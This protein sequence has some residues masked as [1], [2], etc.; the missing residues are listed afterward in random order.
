[1]ISTQIYISSGIIDLEEDIP[2]NL[3]YAIA[4]IREPFN[5][6]ASYSRTITIPGSKANNK[7]FK[8]VFDLKSSVINASNSNFNPD[9]NPN[10]KAECVI[11]VDGI[12]Q[13]KGYCQ[14][15]AINTYDEDR[16]EFEIAVFG[17]VADFYQA[18]GTNKLTD[19]TF[20][21]YNHA[22][23]RS[24]QKNSW[25]TSIVKNEQSQG[26]ALGEGYV[27][28]MID[29]GQ[30]QGDVTTWQV[31]HFFPAIYVW[32]YLQKIMNYAGFTFTLLPDTFREGTFKRLII[33]FNSSQLKLTTSQVNARL[34]DVSISSEIGGTI[35]VFDDAATSLNLNPIVFDT[36][37]LDPSNQNNTG[38]GIV[39]IANKGI[40]DFTF[41][42]TAYIDADSEVVIN[43]PS[44][45]DI[46]FTVIK[47][48]GNAETT[49]AAW[50]LD[51]TSAPVSGGTYPAGTIFVSSR[52][53]TKTVTGIALNANDQIRVVAYCYNGGDTT[54]TGQLGY[55]VS[56]ASFKN[57]VQSNLLMDG[58]TV[59]MNS[60]VPENITMKDF[61]T[62][63]VKMFNIYVEHDDEKTNHLILQTRN[64]FYTSGVTLDWTPKLDVAKITA[65]PMGVLDFK[66]YL[67]TYRDDV[68]YYNK[69]YKDKYGE[70]YGEKRID[71]ANDFQT[72]DKKTDVIF[73]ATTLADKP[74]IDRIIPTIL[75]IDA[76]GVVTHKTV[77]SRILYYGGVKSTTNP[78]TY[79]D[80][81]SNQTETTFPYA[82]HLDSTTA[83]LLDLSFGTPREVY[84]T[85]AVYTDG[86]LY[87]TFH[88]QFIDE[89]TDK[90]SRVLKAYMRL[91]PTDIL[92][93]DFRNTIFI[94]GVKYRLNKIID[95][96]PVFTKLTLCEFIKIKFTT[97][98]TAITGT[99]NGGS[100]GLG[101]EVGPVFSGGSTQ[102]QVTMPYGIARGKNNYID[103]LA[104]AIVQGDNNFVGEGAEGA[105][106]AS[107]GV[108]VAPGVKR[109]AVFN[110][111]GVTVTEDDQFIVNNKPMAKLN[112]RTGSLTSAQILAMGVTG[113]QVVENPG[114]NKSI[115]VI[116]WW[117]TMN[118]VSA[119]Y[120]TNTTLQLLNPGSGW[121]QMYDTKT[122]T[123]TATRTIQAERRIPTDNSDTQI[124]SNIGLN[125]RTQNGNP[126]GGSG[127]LNYFIIYQII[128]T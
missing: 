114:A 73:A 121:E 22:Y 12:T 23:N 24:N 97:P 53:I 67:Y 110:S 36:E 100:G 104:S 108:V 1:M 29:Y 89:I 127:T 20:N 57:A 38:T 60:V 120:A 46:L 4:D 39:T 78:W 115:K 26:F 103:E 87:N 118:Y 105:I 63:I 2:L 107:S 113:Y 5:R 95:Y 82:G 85:T 65:E 96:D 48:V 49:L 58:N 45:F 68:D 54:N 31:E 77:N 80:S 13:L 55:N 88:K 93:L 27:Y 70:V 34:F 86:N 8:S 19:L 99:I 109:F 125:I 30:N 50:W 76:K 44:Q 128:D 64:D 56:A 15:L 21:E 17:R 81:T 119:A 40:Y 117:N 79:K 90:D 83:P 10:I 7:V 3:N 11:K 111:S 35:N 47:K 74:N 61:F 72:Q 91:T 28:P 43:S 122:L 98:F 94:D 42:A 41:G 75:N 92:T 66:K 37:T 51:S 84:Y 33:P 9:F 123:S 71:V 32:T 25:A 126:T 18:M 106:F 14:L 52:S 59:D 116:D 16:I 69:R 6:N 101:I 102:G 62:S 124:L 112:Y